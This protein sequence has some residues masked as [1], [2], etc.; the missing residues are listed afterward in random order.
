M[1]RNT[2]IFIGAIAILVAI[3]VPLTIF[4]LF[5]NP[6]I[7]IEE[8][9]LLVFS[10]DGVDGEYR[11][12]SV[13][14]LNI[15]EYGPFVNLNVTYNTSYPAVTWAEVSGVSLWKVINASGMLIDGIDTSYYEVSLIGSDGYTRTLDLDLIE[16]YPNDIFIIYGGNDFDPVNDGPLRSAMSNNVTEFEAQSRYW[17]SNLINITINQKYLLVFS[18][19]GL[20]EEY[21][22]SS[23]S[24]LNIT[25]FGPF[26]NLN[27][28]YN[29]TIAIT[30]AEV[31]GVSLWKV[32][33]A[34]KML[35]DGIDTSYYEVS[36]IA[37]DGY[38]R[39]LDLDLIESYPDDIFIIYG[40]NDF[41]P[42]NDG[43]FRSAMSNNVTEFEAQSRYWVR[44]LER[45]TIEYV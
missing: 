21:K 36:L 20:D 19:D 45:I 12:S 44:N 1:E 37:S 10:G 6:P 30:W 13:D 41:D 31:S 5:F 11:I 28:T 35:I 24:E 23:I 26:V 17:V 27:V 34:S 16:K 33:N 40:G 38:T 43:P 9:T 39:T 2:N 14:E 15:P 3:L 4:F 32:I 29:T 42:V 22:V 18:G 7:E 8:E 25:E